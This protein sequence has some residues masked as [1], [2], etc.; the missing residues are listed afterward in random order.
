MGIKDT[1]RCDYCGEIDVIEHMFVHCNRLKGFWSMVFNNIFSRTNLRIES[2]D[3]NILFGISKT[4]P[5]TKST[6]LNIINHI[7]LIAKMCI[8][9]TKFCGLANL[10]ITFE[11]ELSAREHYLS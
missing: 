10:F 5:P 3:Q 11:L 9:K 7:I 2:T 1:E 6:N 8:S 4:D